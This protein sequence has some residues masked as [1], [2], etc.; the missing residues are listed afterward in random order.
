MSSL[1]SIEQCT[2]SEKRFVY[3]CTSCD[4]VLDVSKILRQPGDITDRFYGRCPSCGSALES[5]IECQLTAFAED[6]Q[7][8][9]APTQ[10]R[11]RPKSVVFQQA[12]SYMRFSLDFLPLDRLLQPLQPGNLVILKGPGASAIAELL[13]FRAQLLPEQGGL[14][15][16]TFFIDGGNCSDPYLLASLARPYSLDARKALRRVINCRLFTMYQLA[17]LFSSGRIA[18]LAGAHGC[19]LVILADLLGMFNEPDMNQ[20]EIDRLLAAIRQGLLATKKKLVVV[21][22]LGSPNKYAGLVS[23]WADTFVQLSP[24]RGNRTHAALLRHPTK[25]ADASVFSM[26]Q[27]LFRPE[28]LTW[29]QQQVAR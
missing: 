11:R 15:S 20:V 23:D 16:G 24:M 19:R 4:D 21:A 1:Y 26:S 17:G 8:C 29:Q 28:S 27:L 7:S 6:A 5:S 14:D 9:E 18:D 25:N 3:Y 22:T 13:A 2:H 10:Q 12:S